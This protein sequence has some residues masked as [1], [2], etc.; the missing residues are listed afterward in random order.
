MTRCAECGR[1][2][3][4]HE[5]YER[6]LCV[7]CVLDRQRAQDA[8]PRTSPWTLVVVLLGAVG[9]GV[10]LVAVDGTQYDSRFDDI[11]YGLL[12]L[13]AGGLIFGWWR[14]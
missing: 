11:V 3:E 12:L 1:L 4:G 7:Q 6:N 2:L 13:A 9:L 5:D 8:T 10:A 14:S